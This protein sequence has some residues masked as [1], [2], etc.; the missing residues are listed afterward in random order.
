MVFRGREMSVD[1]L[2]AMGAGMFK[3]TAGMGPKRFCGNVG[4]RCGGS[5]PK[6]IVQSTHRVCGRCDGDGGRCWGYRR[7][8]LWAIQQA[9]QS[10]TKEI[11]DGAAGNGVR[12]YRRWD[13]R[14]YVQ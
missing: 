13:R 11:Q 8:S 14:S 5:E 6:K 10:S 3:A 4:S 12:R 1:P 7:G 2:G 9:V